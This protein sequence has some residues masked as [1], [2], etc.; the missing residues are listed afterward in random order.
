M[1]S[2]YLLV[3]GHGRPGGGF[4]GGLV[5][6]MAFVLRYLPGGKRELALAIPVRPAV[7]LGGGLLVTLATGAAGWLMGDAFLYATSYH[8]HAPVIGEIHLPTSLFFD[9]GVYLLVL[10]LVL[11]ILTTLGASLEEGAEQTR[12]EREGRDVAG[13]EPR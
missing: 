8:W 4:V 6:G 9:V 13:E 3:A 5:A 12:A 7:L 10:G 2:I 11:T 1:V